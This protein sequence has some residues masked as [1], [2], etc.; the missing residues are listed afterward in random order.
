[1]EVYNNQAVNSVLNIPLP[2][3]VHSSTVSSSINAMAAVTVEDMIKPYTNM[4]EKHLTW[5]SKGLSMF[6]LIASIGQ[7]CH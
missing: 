5:L 6:T 1:M 4:S 2:D 7:V 3:P